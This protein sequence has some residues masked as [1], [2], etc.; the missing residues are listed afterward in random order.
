MYDCHFAIESAPGA[1]DFSF[2]NTRLITRA[3]GARVA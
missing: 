1:T 2:T 3:I